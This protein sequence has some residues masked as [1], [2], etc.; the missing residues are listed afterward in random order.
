LG[1]QRARKRKGSEKRELTRHEEEKEKEVYQAPSISK[2]RKAQVPRRSDFNRK[3]KVDQAW[4]EGESKVLSNSGEEKN[5]R[6]NI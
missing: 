4:G 6:I 3:S 1:H 5:T 2:E